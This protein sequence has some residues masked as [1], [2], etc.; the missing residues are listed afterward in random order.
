MMQIKIHRP[1]VYRYYEYLRKNHLGKENKIKSKEL[2]NIMGVKLP[3]QKY[4]LKEINE[5]QDFDKLISTC[6]AI[7]MCR[8]QKECEL[9]IK[10][11]INVGLTRLQK[12]KAMAQKLSRNNQL[13]LKLGQY[14]K[15]V[16]EVFEV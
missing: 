16:F 2:S 3:T 5:S 9:A 12:G 7:Y 13:K 10:N 4:I 14:Y 8:T 15:Q 11:E 6:G 1:I